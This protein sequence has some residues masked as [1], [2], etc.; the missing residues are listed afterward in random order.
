[1]TDVLYFQKQRLDRGAAGISSTMT[2]DAAAKELLANDPTTNM[3]KLTSS[4]TNML[5]ALGQLTMKPATGLFAGMADVFRFLR[6]PIHAD[7]Q[8]PSQWGKGIFWNPS[9]FPVDKVLHADAPFNAFAPKMNY[10][11]DYG[12]EAERGRALGALQAPAPI[13]LTTT[14]NF[15]VDGAKIASIIESKL[16]G[17]GFTM[18]H[19][20][21]DS[22]A[23]YSAPDVSGSG[24][25]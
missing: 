6:D 14:N 11:A 13:S 17:A 1:M 16:I 25:Q 21:Q 3:N 22:H 18:G 8:P 24:H 23:F 7:W 5:T 4:L 15:F 2:T 12:R 20:Q 9:Q 19:N 10:G